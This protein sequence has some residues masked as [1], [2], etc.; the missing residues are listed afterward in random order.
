MDMPVNSHNQSLEDAPQIEGYVLSRVLGHGGFGAVYEA[1]TDPPSGT[2]LAV[3]VLEQPLVDMGDFEA[4]FLREVRNA[5]RL[6]HQNIV[7]VLDF[8]AIPDGRLY[9]AMELC[10][11]PSLRMLV[12]RSGPL[13]PVQVA[14]LLCQVLDGLGVAQ[15]EIE[16]VEALGKVAGF[17]VMDP[18]VGMGAGLDYHRGTQAAAVRLGADQFDLQKMD[19]LSFGQ[20]ADQHQRLRVEV[21]GDD[22]QVSVVVQVEY[23]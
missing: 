21:V 6:D 18:G 23:H 9:C 12:F 10:N 8:G 13:P 1:E 11:G 22:V 16:G 3:K 14:H 17:P 7:K 15:A 5:Q 2:R 20:V 4:R 19:L